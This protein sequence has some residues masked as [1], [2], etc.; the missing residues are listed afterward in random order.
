MHYHL[1]NLDF[2]YQISSTEIRS[3]ISIGNRG[4]IKNHLTKEID[5]LIFDNG[6][7]VN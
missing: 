1:Y 3:E 2:D 6:L 5:R 4:K 7:Y